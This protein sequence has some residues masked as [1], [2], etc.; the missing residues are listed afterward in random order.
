MTITPV[1]LSLAPV[2]LLAP[3]SAIGIAGSVLIAAS[4]CLRGLKESIGRREVGA[5]LPIVG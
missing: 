1:A 5:I 2:S 4:G 3:M